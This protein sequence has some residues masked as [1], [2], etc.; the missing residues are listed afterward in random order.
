MNSYD[1]TASCRAE[2]SRVFALLV[3]GSTWPDWS[4]IDAYDAEAGAVDGDPAALAAGGRAVRVFRTG[5]NVS[6]ERIVEL[7]P[8]R[9]LAYEMLSGSG[10]LRKYRGQIDVT[11]QTGG[12]TR[13]RWRGVWRSPVPGVGWFMQRYLRAFQQRMVDGLARHAD[14]DPDTP[15]PSP[16]AS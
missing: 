10:L 8:D 12:G 15:H 13:I 6:R 7:V 16:T 9:R 14:H 2:P 4:P 5:R 11:A 1:V 3:D